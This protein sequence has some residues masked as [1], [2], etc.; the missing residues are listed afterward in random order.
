[1]MKKLLLA[2]LLAGP[3]LAQ[4]AQ[5]ENQD[6]VLQAELLPGWRMADGHY[7]AA[8]DLQMAPEW[9]TYWRAPGEAGIPPTFDWAGSKN[10]KSV[11]FHWPSPRA[12][13]QNGLTS[14]GYLNRLV[15]PV[16][17]VPR[18][19]TQPVTLALK[20]DLGICH[21]ICMPAHLTFAAALSGAGA[22]DPV[23]DAALRAGPKV[24]N[25]GANCA[26]APISDGLRLTARIALPAQGKDETVIFETPDPGIW[27]SEATSNRDGGVL[28]AEADLV[29]PAGAPFALDRSGVTVTVL[30]ADRSIELHGCPAP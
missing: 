11:A 17:V 25:T 12:I 28:V 9:K 26:V 2:L 29:P 10:L 20:M 18:D 1:M 27:V 7:M 19:P 14:I 8:L 5:A 4:T 23:I 15:L 3:V 6:E 21:D 22:P 24:E 16:E 30:G 13:T